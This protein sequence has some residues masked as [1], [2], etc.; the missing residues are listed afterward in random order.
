MIGGAPFFM[1]ALERALLDVGI[2][3]LYAFSIR[4]SVEKA[5]ED[6][7]VTKINVFKHVG[8][9]EANLK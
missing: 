2:T 1:S 7:T 9:V 3:P 5:A 6:G 4:E 8:F